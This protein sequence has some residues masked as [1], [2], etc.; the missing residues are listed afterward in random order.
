MEPNFTLTEASGRLFVDREELVSEMV[1]SLSEPRIRM[2]YALYGIRR[3]GK[4]SILLEVERRLAGKKGVVPVYFNVWDLDVKT[5]SEF[6]ESLTSKALTA[7]EKIIGLK[8]TKRLKDY[9]EDALKLI[10]QHVKLEAKILEEVEVL[11]KYTEVEKPKASSVN[12]ALETLDRI[13]RQTNT[14]CVLFLD[15]FPS[16]TELVY[17]GKRIGS[18]MIRSIR[19]TYGQKLQNTV[20]CIAGS[21]KSTMDATVLG[22]ASPFY[23]QLIVREVKPLEKK[24]VR[25]IITGGVD[26][27]V[28]DDA[29][30]RIYEFTKGIPFYVQ[31]I[32]RQLYMHDRKKT[33]EEKIGAII[34]EFLEEEGNLIFLRELKELSPKEIQLVVDMAAYGITKTSELARKHRQPQ[35]NI[36]TYMRYLL[37]KGVLEKTGKGEYEFTDPIFKKWIKKRYVE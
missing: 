2:G 3:I 36:H 17:N 37:D 12:D 8:K 5:V 9:S 10:L 28:T 16:V 26:W 30:D 32:G 22:K 1:E 33:D 7:Y 25:E 14:R 23:R 11:L 19:V 20:L 34:D 15:E 35:S 4:S 13:A 24:Y 18:Q 21:T 29:V 27:A 6:V 31:F